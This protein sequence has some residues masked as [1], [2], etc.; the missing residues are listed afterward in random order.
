MLNI[1]NTTLNFTF[2]LE[3]H[4]CL[5]LATGCVLEVCFCVVFSAWWGRQLQ[6]AWIKLRKEMGRGGLPGGPV[7]VLTVYPQHSTVVASARHSHI[8][9]RGPFMSASLLPSL[10]QCSS[11]SFLPSS[12]SHTFFCP[13][14]LFIPQIPLFSAS[15]SLLFQVL[16]RGRERDRVSSCCGLSTSTSSP[17][18]ALYSSPRGWNIQHTLSSFIS[19]DRLYPRLNSTRF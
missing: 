7:S 16:R 19:R 4:F 15:L 18:S 5:S 2:Y 6:R 12:L 1:I 14:H 9:S 10:S 3:Q 8:P 17:P 13:P 11:V